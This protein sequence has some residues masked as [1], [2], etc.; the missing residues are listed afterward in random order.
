MF[1]SVQSLRKA[2]HSYRKAVK[3]IQD[4]D[5]AEL[6]IALARR[7]DRQATALET[8]QQECGAHLIAWDSFHSPTI[9]RL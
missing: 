8:K 7:C 5:V 1:D 2:A 3:A 4:E 9:S 6:F